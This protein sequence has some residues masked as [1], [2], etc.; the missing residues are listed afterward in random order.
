MANLEEEK[1][2]KNKFTKISIYFFI[3][4][5]PTQTQILILKLTL[6]L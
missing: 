2:L 5:A 3:I 1:L 6:F 4:L